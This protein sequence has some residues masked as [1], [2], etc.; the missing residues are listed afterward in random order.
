[1]FDP[2]PLERSGM[3]STRISEVLNFRKQLPPLVTNSHI[4]AIVQSPTTVEREIAALVTKGVVRRITIPGR[5]V[6]GKA[7][8]DGIALTEHWAATIK[9]KA[10]KGATSNTT[11]NTSNDGPTLSAS[12][13][14]KYIDFLTSASSD[15]APLLESL[16][17]TELTTLMRSGFVTASS[18]ALRASTDVFSATHHGNVAATSK[19][20]YDSVARAASGSV[21]AVGGVG[22]VLGSGGGGGGNKGKARASYGT[23]ESSIPGGSGTI[24]DLRLTLPSTGAYL[25]LVHGARSAL[26][27]MLA[28]AKYQEA[29]LY[30]LRERWDGNVGTKAVY[31]RSKDPFAQALPGKIRKWKEFYGVRFDWVLAEC[32][33]AGLVEVFETG[34]VGL[35]VR[36]I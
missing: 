33:G 23:S 16:N 12:L 22:A 1:M 5:G 7:I 34:S 30:L 28:K 18:T 19:T 25:K 10:F 20:S 2:V 24:Y 13:A 32:L 3:S 14:E 15:T 17:E 36:T 9:D 31:G 35:G 8:G 21:N 4:H 27:A 11:P 29:P 6:G 26:V